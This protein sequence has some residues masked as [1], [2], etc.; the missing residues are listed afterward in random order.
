MQDR[1]I[2]AIPSYSSSLQ[3]FCRLVQ[4]WSQRVPDQ[5]T[6]AAICEVRAEAIRITRQD[7]TVETIDLLLDTLL[8]TLQHA[9]QREQRKRWTTPLKSLFK[10]TASDIV[11]Q[12]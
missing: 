10:K 9:A 8:N 6:L 1:A 4:S 12:G 3:D 7:A 5:Q 2:H 11:G